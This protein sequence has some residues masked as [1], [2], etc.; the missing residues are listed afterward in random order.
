MLAMYSRF[1]TNFAIATFSLLS[2]HATAENVLL[3][4]E[5][6]LIPVFTKASCNAGACHGAALGR[7][8]FK[9]SLYGGNP[10]A[11]YD[12]IVRQLE[13]RRI[14]L[15]DPGSSLLLQKPTET[16]EHGGGFRFDHGDES[17][18]RIL[19]WIEQGASDKSHRT[20]ERVVVSPRQIRAQVGDTTQLSATARFSD[21]TQQDVTRWTIFH[22]EDASAVEVQDTAKATVV[23][24]GRHIVVARYLNQVVPIEFVVPLNDSKANLAKEPR[25]NFIDE[26]VLALLKALRLPVSPLVEDATFIRRLTLDL[27]GR[28]PIADGESIPDEAPINRAALVDELLTSEAF[29][30]YWTLEFAKLLRIR[31]QGDGN[32]RAAKTYHRWLTEQIKQDAGFDQL[33][34]DLILALGDTHENGPA[35]FYRTVK[36]PREQAEFVSELFMGSRLRCANCHNHPLDHWTQDDYH[37]LAAIF[38]KLATGQVIKRNPRGD[39]IHPRTLEAAIAKTPGLSVSPTNSAEPDE[40]KEFAD[41]LTN[42]D[43]PYFAKAIVNRL[44]KRLM[45][46]GLVEPADDFRGDQSRDAPCTA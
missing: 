46:R 18:D 16:I 12:A 30:E 9:L 4:F 25:R 45:G 35:N 6:D 39:V 29:T 17:A 44:W 27:T 21:G 40:R 1:L 2:F 42:S 10:A 26:E 24:R 33:A 11:D 8:G 5:N 13:G 3:D 14:N 43:N 37:G 28:L 20:L 31:P 23:R 7:G 38:A 19:H 34:R 22:A 41:W 32:M 15:A 36:G